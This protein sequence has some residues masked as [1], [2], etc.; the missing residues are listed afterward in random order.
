MGR[1]TRALRWARGAWPLLA[2]LMLTLAG[3]AEREEELIIDGHAHSACVFHDPDLIVA[4]LDELG[5]DKVVLCPG[6]VNDDKNERVPAL[7]KLSGRT[8]WMLPVNRVIRSAAALKKQKEDLAARNELVHSFHE[9]HPDRIE[10]FYWADP[11]ADDFLEDL[12]SKHEA[13]GFRG[14]KLH[15]CVERFGMDAPVLRDMAE[16]AG[17]KGLPVFIHIYSKAGAIRTMDLITSHRRTCFVIAHL[18]GLEVFESLPRNVENAYFE[19]SPA[20]LISDA[21]VMKA[22]ERFRAARII[23]GSDT[24]HGTDG[25]ARNLER[26]R[27]LDIPPKQR[28]LVLGKNME[29][30]LEP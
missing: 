9:K 8:D 6:I 4:K 26:V 5:V 14:I 13:W 19:I 3:A 15:Q 1:F 16:F 28:D 2:I 7:A 21:R 22:I 18:I 17:D 23:F 20:P 12:A 25:L 27:A 11:A 29:R 30:L 10:Q 24:P